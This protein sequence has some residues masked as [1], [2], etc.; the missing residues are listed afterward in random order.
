MRWIYYGLLVLMMEACGKE[1]KNSINYSKV[2]DQYQSI[3]QDLE[4]DIYSK[5]GRLNSIRDSEQSF[6]AV[7]KVTLFNPMFSAIYAVQSRFE[8]ANA[9]DFPTHQLILELNILKQN[10]IH[11][12]KNIRPLEYNDEWELLKLELLDYLSDLDIEQQAILLKRN[13]ELGLT[14]SKLLVK[15]LEYELVSKLHFF[16]QTKMVEN[17]PQLVFCSSQ[18]KSLLRLVYKDSFISKDPME[19]RIYNR[20][21]DQAHQSSIS[22][23]TLPFSPFPL[24]YSLAAFWKRSGYTYSN[25]LN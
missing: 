6:A 10:L 2:I 16:A 20:N 5:R 15:K 13:Y 22:S 24:N 1:D 8:S 11:Y 21:T 14:S 7:F 17:Q 12:C 3:I 19:Y 4:E 23:I 18:G 25:S 9:N